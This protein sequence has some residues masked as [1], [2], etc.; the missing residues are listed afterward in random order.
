M[1]IPTPES[2]PPSLASIYALSKFDQE[3]MCLPFGRAYN[4]PRSRCDF[5]TSTAHARRF[6]SL[7]RACWRSSPRGCLND[8][9]PLSLRMATSS[10]ISSASTTWPK[11]RGWRW[12]R[13][14]LLTG[15]QRGQRRTFT[16]REIAETMALALRKEHIAPEITENI[17]WAIFVIALPTSP[18]ARN[19]LGYKPRVALAE[20]LRELADWL[21]GQV[22]VD[23]VAQARAELASRGLTV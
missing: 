23:N 17:A 21:E 12:R 15:L 19:L 3:R 16:I 6:E 20:G 7:H 11:P 4:I 5:S 13:L 10:A 2:K 22:A 18:G 8:N 9:P 1:P 14:P